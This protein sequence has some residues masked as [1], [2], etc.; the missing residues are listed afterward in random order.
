[1]TREDVG[2]E[3][4]SVLERNRPMKSIFAKTNPAVEHVFEQAGHPSKVMC[5]PLDYAKRTHTALVCNGSGMQLKKP[6][7]VHNNPE[8]LEFLIQITE[9]LCRKHAIRREH[10]IFAGED[11]GSFCLNFIHALAQ[12]GRLL[13]GVNPSAAAEERENKN[14]STDELDL[15][16]IASLVINKKQ[17]RT[18]SGEHG[19]A[20][21]VRK[22]T[23]Y[24]NSLIKSHCASAHRIHAIVDQLLPGF[25]NERLS[26]LTPFS[27][28]S[29]WLMSERF[30]PRQVRARRRDILIRKLHGLCVTDAEKT[31]DH[32][33]QL[34]DSCL[35]PPESLCES[36]QV[37]LT[38]EVAIY[39]SLADSIAQIHQRIARALAP[40]PGAMLCTVPGIGITL[41]SGLYAQIADPPR[42]RTVEQ[43]ASYAGIVDRLKQTGGPEGEAHSR[44]RSRRGHR[45]LKRLIVDIALKM[46]QY[47]HEELKTDYSRREALGQ[48]VRFTMARRMLRICHHL[49]QHTDFFV[50]PSLLRNATREQLRTYYSQAWNPMLVKWRN[51]GAILQ[52]FAPG[53]PLEEWRCTLNER[54]DLS[55][56][57]KSPQA[58][59][60]RQ[61]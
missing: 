39:Q 46:G 49:I 2:N 21:V 18:I 5:V 26:G 53:T 34:A 60:L 41:G 10:V 6:F 31:A 14:A 40:T 25:L 52:A 15:L 30:S 27:R 3:A 16:G 47:G 56:S 9:G 42:Q 48:D 55:L 36:L 43:L 4:A 8:G 11:C 7:H 51:A 28:A 12:K 33:R 19:S 29:L 45:V 23:R 37:S 50:P 38:H 54:Y 17:G 35:P 32:I 20:A 59:D 44:G 57:K 58:A 1:M 22:L 13:L 61:G 24:R